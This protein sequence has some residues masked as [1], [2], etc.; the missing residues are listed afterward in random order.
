[1]E[2]AEAACETLQK[3]RYEQM[4]CR[5]GFHSVGMNGYNSTPHLRLNSLGGL[6]KWYVS[7]AVIGGNKCVNRARFVRVQQVKVCYSIGGIKIIAANPLE[8][9]TGL[10]IT[11][12]LN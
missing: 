10:L 7:T 2:V 11:F 3:I 5:P 9:F 8:T 4:G 1:M 6:S 12:P